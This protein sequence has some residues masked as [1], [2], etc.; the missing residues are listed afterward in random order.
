MQT[1]DSHE[2]Y[3]RLSRCQGVLNDLNL[4]RL[5]LM[6]IAEL[7]DGMVSEIEFFA[8][9]DYY[10]DNG[11]CGDCAIRLANG[12]EPNDGHQCEE[13]KGFNNE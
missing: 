13:H 3:D 4:D 9:M 6:M 10:L 8:A 1:Q 5:E 12:E 7:A 2:Y 11:M